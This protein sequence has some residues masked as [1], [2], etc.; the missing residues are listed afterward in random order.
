MCECLSTLSKGRV[1]NNRGTCLLGLGVG[2]ATCVS[3]FS[4][5][6]EGRLLELLVSVEAALCI[7]L[8]VCVLSLSS[9]PLDWLCNLSH[10]KRQMHN[11]DHEWLFY[12]SSSTYGYPVSLLLHMFICI[13]NLLFLWLCLILRVCW[14]SQGCGPLRETMFYAWG[15][16]VG[17]V[18]GVE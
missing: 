12:F 15:P 16:R 2:S 13:S 14:W 6:I 1:K 18:M 11:A 9:I 3:V 7:C 5:S 10:N 8:Y 17:P 4:C